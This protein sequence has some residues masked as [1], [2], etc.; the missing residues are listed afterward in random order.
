MFKGLHRVSTNHPCE[1]YFVQEPSSCEH[2]PSVWSVKV[3]L[4]ESLHRVSTNHPCEGYFAR[5]PSSCDT[6]H[7]CEGYFAQEPSSCQHQPSVWRL[8]C[9][10]A[11]LGWASTICVKVTLHKSL[12]P[13]STNHPCEGYFAQ[14]PSSCEHQP[15]MWRLLCTR[16]FIV[17]AHNHLLELWSVEWYLRNLNLVP[18]VI[19][20]ISFFHWICCYHSLKISKPLVPISNNILNK[21]LMM[22]MGLAPPSVRCPSVTS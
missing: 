1:G 2:Q 21:F 16:A 14:K 8:L 10:R 4:H 6:N 11:F 19:Y 7:P 18:T 9:T 5:E 15:S 17:W 12:H 3:T 22:W 13:V 20:H